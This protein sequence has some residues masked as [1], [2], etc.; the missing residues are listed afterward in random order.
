MAWLGQILLFVM[1]GLLSFPSRLLAVAGEGLL[2]ALVLIVVARPLAVAVAALPFRF[3]RRKLVFLSWVGLKGAVPITLPTFPLMAGVPQSNT[4]FNA[5]F[6]VVL[7]SVITQ[8]WSLP[9]VA[10][11]LHIGR[12]ADPTPALSVEINALR[13]VDG[14]IVDYTVK[15]NAQVAGQ[16]LRDLALPDG[17]LVTLI[18]RGR[19]VLM[20]R[21][22]TTLEAG[23]HVFV[24]LRSRLQPWI[25]R[26]FDPDPDEASLPEGL[27][28]T[29]NAATSVEQLHRFFGVAIPAEI[30]PDIAAR[31]LADLVA[32]TAE[33]SEVQVGSFGLRAG[34]DQ[35]LVTACWL[36]EA[37]LR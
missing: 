37:P 35:D 27:V 29:F 21:G 28:L 32:N 30:G 8:G 25:D 9:L 14:E 19:Q 13:Q 1:L 26:L 16:Q 34:A 7:I 12:P 23:D 4:I 18:L 36:V 11:W 15:P 22:G 17:M 24:A 10:R 5:V 2:I 20:P 31:S 33:G 6:F 3:R